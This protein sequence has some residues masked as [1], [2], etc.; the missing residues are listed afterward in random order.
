[1]ET[2]SRILGLILGCCLSAAIYYWFPVAAYAQT[3]FYVPSS[4]KLSGGLGIM[5]SE[6]AFLSEGH[7]SVMAHLGIGVNNNSKLSVLVG[8]STYQERV[9]EQKRTYGDLIF[10]Y[11]EYYPVASEVNF[12]GIEGYIFT[13]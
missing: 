6:E 11:T 10:T 13:L 9:V 1:M 5:S 8:S 4:G 2:N 3:S 7:A 12:V